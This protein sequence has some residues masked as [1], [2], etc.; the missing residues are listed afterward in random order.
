MNVGVPVIVAVR[1][2]GPA[3]CAVN[4]NDAG[5][6]ACV[7]V[8]LFAASGSVAVAVIVAIAAPS[9][10]DAVAGAVIAGRWFGTVVIVNTVVALAVIVA[11]AA[12]SDPDAVAGA[13]IDGA[14]FG[15]AV[16]VR[17]VFVLAVALV[18]P[19]PSLTVHTMV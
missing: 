16:I 12:P 4:V 11:I 19:E 5:F 2:E 9:D 6:P 7:I 17:T 13:E 14:W 3:A 18:A 1:G 15:A 10:P 8:R